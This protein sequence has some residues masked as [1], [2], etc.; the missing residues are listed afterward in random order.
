VLL[1]LLSRLLRRPGSAVKS[2][3]A[4]LRHYR[5]GDLDAAERLCG[6]LIARAAPPADAFFLRGLIAEQKSDLPRAVEQFRAAI[7]SR[8]ADAA[9][10][11]R[12]AQALLA[13]GRGAEARP[14]L[15]RALQLT[16]VRHASRAGLFRLLVRVLADLQEE[17]AVESLCRATLREQSDEPEALSELGLSLYRQARTEEARQQFG[18]LFARTGGTAARIR[19]LLML[20]HINAS[21]E[22]ID[23]VRA[24]MNAELDALLGSRLEAVPHPERDVGLTAFFLAYHGRNDRELLSKLGRLYR[25]V[26]PVASA[27]P[28]RAPGARLRIGFISRFFYAHSIARTTHGLIRDLP[29]ERFEVLVFSVAGKDDEWSRRIRADCDRYVELPED[30]DAARVALQSARLDVLFFADIGMDALTY[31]LAYWRFAPLQ[32]T[33]WGHPV[34]SGIDSI[35][36]F[37]SAEGLEG[38]GSEDQYSEALI[39]LPAFYNPGY[40]RPA[41]PAV[42]SREELG[43][44]ASGPLYLCPQFLFKLH[45]D[46]DGALAAIVRESPNAQ[47]LLLAAKREAKD[48]VRVRIDAALGAQAARVRILGRM[49]AARYYEVLSAV[50]VVL[51]PFHFG[52]NNT[53]CEAFAFGKPIVTLP[54]DFL[55]GRYTLAC[56]REMH[57]DECVA[58][59]PADFARI[60]VSLGEERERRE[61]LSARIR[62]RSHVLF[63]RSDAARALAD[64]ISDRLK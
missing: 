16:P 30:L 14:H 26:Y 44:P 13:L 49:P 61:A 32:L 38:T 45:P 63:E 56:Y 18:R 12:L 42:R 22:R 21:N 11:L 24:R 35:D 20:P 41:T 7:A 55:R 50:D 4:A 9:F 46:F 58:S 3:Q 27:A 51:D 39:K 31:F 19:Q 60:A 53:T 43:L 33:T 6:D 36:A 52:G 64:A 28:R 1:G 5:A 40:R 48:Q 23:E 47:I 2:M 25:Q 10:Q 17:A 62:E 29:R 37:I 34:T 15:E 54:A 59:S 57:I 8:E